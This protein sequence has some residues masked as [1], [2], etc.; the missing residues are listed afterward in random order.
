[1]NNK[2]FRVLLIEDSPTDAHLVRETLKESL[3]PSFVLTHAT[4]LDDGLAKL[5]REQFDL[6]VLDLALPDS[7]GLETF[8]TVRDHGPEVPIVILTGLVGDDMALR[9]FREGA[10]D[11]LPKT[12]LF[13][14]E[15]ARSL[16]YAIERT[17]L[18]PARQE[19][20]AGRRNSEN[21]PNLPGFLNRPTLTI[22]ASVGEIA[23]RKNRAVLQASEVSYRRLFET[24]QDGILI[25]ESETGR[26]TDV[27]PFLTKLLGFSRAEMIGQT[28]G[29]L[30][31]FKDHVANEAMLAELQKQGYVRYEHLPLETKDGRKIDVEFVSNQYQAG[32]KSVIQCNVRDI[33]ARRQAEMVLTRLAA[34]VEFSDD[35]IIG[36]D[37]NGIIT[38]W[39]K[40]AEKI[41]GYTASEMVG[42]S[43]MRLISAD[44]HGEEYD[45]LNKIKRG[46][47]VM[48]FETLRQA[49]DGRLMEVSV[50][51]SPIKDR[52]GQIIG[53]S[54][55]AH[56]IGK[57]KTAE[58]KFH[59][60]NLE[61]EERVLERTAELQ[62]LN[63][64]LE[65]FSYSVSH[66][67]RAPLRHITGF[68]KLLQKGVASSL[69]KTNLQYLTTI[70]ESAERMGE[71]IDNLLAFS[72]VGRM[73][74]QKTEFD[75]AALV[76]ETVGGF[77]T[78][79]DE[80]N[81][82]WEIGPL[83]AVWADP[84]LL[85]LALV[86]LL[87]N[88]VK[89]TSTRVEAKIEIGCMSNGSGDTEI[90]IRDNG[91]GFDPKYI[92]KLFGVFQRLH[93]ME[94][95]EGTGIGLANVKRIILRHGGRIWAKG[96]VDGGAT[97][98]FS[99]PTKP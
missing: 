57:R 65:T 8:F 3:M 95:F 46:E 15:L 89:F 69:S 88:A 56:D 17:R 5:L 54:K 47:P 39:N 58:K 24:A 11:C 49:K 98:S 27:N 83:P 38:D 85:R 63:L 81:I 50:T 55:V 7:H 34:I 71:L 91:V 51:A 19:A 33:T 14:G 67:L 93:S 25:L 23:E 74:L 61:L 16:H 28:V 79:T 6:T 82:V 12:Y 1:M 37:L 76:K 43:I 9:A 90:F 84:V 99:L 53:V 86:N 70:S 72:R 66:D 31:P 2:T 30:S 42:S 32:G 97:F 29:E 45:I 68:V 20:E 13:N 44:R 62:A 87:S 92:D 18:Q 96:A 48:R 22:G 10:A 59:Q 75:L 94:E 26:I 35:A 40:G 36:K 64:E 77:A 21:T 52:D 41:F 60:L 78:E 80:R 73:E 4:R